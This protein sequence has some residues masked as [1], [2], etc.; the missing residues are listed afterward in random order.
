MAND[1]A[2]VIVCPAAPA[3]PNETVAQCRQAS[4]EIERQQTQS[5]R[6]RPVGEYESN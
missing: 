5:E 2:M 1:H 4:L 6:Q 3:V